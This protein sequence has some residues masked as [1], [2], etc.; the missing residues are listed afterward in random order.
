MQE[1]GGELSNL[2]FAA[3]CPFE[4]VYPEQRERS[5]Q[6]WREKIRIGESHA[7]AQRAQAKRS[8]TRDY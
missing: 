2:I 7:E 3:S 4:E 1:E 6:T 8:T 5:A